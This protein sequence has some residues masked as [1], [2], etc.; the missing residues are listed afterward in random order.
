MPALA[1]GPLGATDGHDRA[2]ALLEPELLERFARHRLHLHADHP[3]RDL[4]RPQLRQQA[5]HDVDRHG[6]A[7]ADVARLARVGVDRRVHAD[8][9]AAHVQQR[10]ARVA[11]VDGGVGLQHVDGAPLADRERPLERADDADADGVR[12]AERVADGHDPVARLHLRRVAELG[13]RQ[14]VVGLFG[15]LDQRAVGQ[16][17]ASHHARAI[18]D[19]V[20]LAVQRDLD[21][22]G[23]LDH[24]VVGEDEAFLGDDEAGAGGHRRAG[25]CRR[26]WAAAAG[27]RSGGTG[28]RRRRTR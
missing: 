10:A 25:R 19:V 7:D 2:R 8:H 27:R 4:A 3:A 24:V 26:D 23:A 9:F 5:A 21:L 12:Q 22:V 20:F 18:P 6:E 17:V 16:R 11:R 28:R 13:L 1:A 15:Q 14:R